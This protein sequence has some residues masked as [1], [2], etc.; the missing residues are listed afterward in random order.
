VVNVSTP[1]R[2][3]VPGSKNL[4]VSLAL[5]DVSVSKPASQN[6]KEAASA[7]VPRIS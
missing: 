1:S 7:P 3:C 4:T 6:L 5:A 2:V